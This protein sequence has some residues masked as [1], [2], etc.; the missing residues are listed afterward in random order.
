MNI[1]KEQFDR[2]LA[3]KLKDTANRSIEIISRLQKGQEDTTIM[4]ALS[5]ERSLVY[6]YIK[7]LTIKE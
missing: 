2:N 4:E 1:P 5:C 6:Y 3:Q 7:K